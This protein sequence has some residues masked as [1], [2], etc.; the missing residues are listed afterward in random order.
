M[1]KHNFGDYLLANGEEDSPAVLE[2]RRDFSFA[3]LRR[4]TDIIARVLR[5]TDLGK[6]ERVAIAGPNSLFW[7][8]SYIAIMR[9]G[10]VAVPLATNLTETELTR[11]LD[12]V[13]CGTVLIDRRQRRN[14]L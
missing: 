6:G 3:D 9:S 14:F 7:I 1:S 5:D 12:W 8:A 13:G 4:A 11:N 10:L 2:A